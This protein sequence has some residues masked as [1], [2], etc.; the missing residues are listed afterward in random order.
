MSFEPEGPPRSEDTTA[1]READHPT[2]RSVDDLTLASLAGVE[3]PDALI[4]S[5]DAG[6][7]RWASS[8]SFRVLGYRPSDLIGQSIEVL[9]PVAVRAAHPAMRKQFLES[10][11]AMLV[12]VNRPLSAVRRDGTELASEIGLSRIEWKGETL[13]LAAVR[14]RSEQVIVERELNQARTQLARADERA[15]VARDLHDTVSQ[16]LYGLGLAIQ[17]AQR[18][19]VEDTDLESFLDQLDGALRRLAG[20]IFELREISD[21]GRILDQ[22]RAVIDMSA[23][24]LGFAPNL[25]LRGNLG[26]ISP[27]VAPQLVFVLRELLSNCAKHSRAERVDVSLAVLDRVP[28]SASRHPGQPAPSTGAAWVELTVVDDGVGFDPSTIDQESAGYGIV[29]VR[30]RADALG[31]LASWT[32]GSTKSGSLGTSATW[33]VPVD[34]VVSSS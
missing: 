29:G 13:V 22:L 3:A 10:G 25:E 30:S 24:A 7:I 11:E 33:T 23:R 6:I 12:G 32:D 19:G 31:G 21:S 18:R 20:V 34:A 9:V 26:R 28:E 1:A 4:L 15:R 5:D 16:D 8:A 14:D 2:V 27:V 17:R